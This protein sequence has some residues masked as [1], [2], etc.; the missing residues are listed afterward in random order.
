MSEPTVYVS[1]TGLQLKARRHT[2]RFWWLAI[3]S[4]MQARQAKG[5]ISTDARQINRVHHTLTV[6]T[7][8]AAM[9]R[10]LVAGAHLQAMKAFG[11]IAT[12]KTLGYYAERVPDWS[13][14]HELWRTKGRTVG[15]P[16]GRTA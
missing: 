10:Y 1:I 8:E 3:R 9:R 6:W 16:E 4:M 2:V 7:D 15:P 12:G 14:V 5:N 11:S 13:E